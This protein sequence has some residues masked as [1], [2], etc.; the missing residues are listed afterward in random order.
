MISSI[1]DDDIRAGFQNTLRSAWFREQIL[2]LAVK[3]S[4]NERA[5]TYSACSYGL[6]GK[7]DA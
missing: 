2:A 6:K 1:V 4:V 5:W 3:I 7:L